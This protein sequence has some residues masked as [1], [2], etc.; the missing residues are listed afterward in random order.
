MYFGI[1]IENGKTI[2]NLGLL[3][4]S[5]ENFGAG[6]IFTAGARYKKHIT[7]IYNSF[8]RIPLYNYKNAEDLY[9][10]L[11]YSCRLVGVENSEGALDLR[12][13]RHLNRAV[14]LLGAEDGGI[15]KKAAA[16]CH[17]IIKIPCEKGCFN[18][19]VAAGIIMYDRVLKLSSGIQSLAYD[20]INKPL[21]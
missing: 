7:D 12:N 17:E 6:F 14:Y 21:K 20:Q 2:Q 15:S 8:Q 5:A 13:Y 9:A 16:L 18:V 19:S 1:G 10:H 3:W 4:R 11:P